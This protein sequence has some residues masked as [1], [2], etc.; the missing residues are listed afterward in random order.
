MLRPALNY[1]AYNNTWLS[2]SK[3]E[4]LTRFRQ[5]RYRARKAIRNTKNEWFNAKAMQIEEKRFG[6]KEV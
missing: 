1:D 4:D 3:R 2:S 6:S 5:A